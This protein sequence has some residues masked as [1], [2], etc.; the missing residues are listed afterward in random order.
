M[1]SRQSTGVEV[2]KLRLRVRFYF[3]EKKVVAK[4]QPRSSFLRTRG[5]DAFDGQ[6]TRPKPRNLSTIYN[7]TPE[8]DRIDN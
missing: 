4:L 2:P 3:V 1:I 5:V 6:T 7:R 8:F